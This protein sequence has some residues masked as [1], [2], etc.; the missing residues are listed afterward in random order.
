M[1]LIF[2][3]WLL[4]GYALLTGAR[5]PVFASDRA[6]WMAALPSAAPRVSANVAAALLREGAWESAGD[7]AL[8]AIEKAQRPE[9]AYEVDAVRHLV[10]LQVQYLDTWHPVCD[11]PVF[12]PYCF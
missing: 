7:Y 12:A 9:S 1:R 4:A 2:A 3:V 5:I 10:Q 11:R 6:L 8:Q